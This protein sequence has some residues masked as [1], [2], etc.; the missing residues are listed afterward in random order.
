M[1]RYIR[2]SEYK[3]NY[4]QVKNDLNLLR[5]LNDIAN[6]YGAEIEIHYYGGDRFYIELVKYKDYTVSGGAIKVDGEW[7]ESSFGWI[8]LPVP[9]LG[10]D[11]DYDVI[12]NKVV[13]GFEEFDSELK[14]YTKAVDYLPTAQRTV[15]EFCSYFSNLPF[16]KKHPNLTISGEAYNIVPFPAQ[17]ELLKED[18]TVAIGAMFNLVDSDIYM[19]YR[20]DV[21]YKELQDFK[22][23][24]QEIK[25]DIQKEYNK[26]KRENSDK[27]E[28]LVNYSLNSIFKENGFTNW[29]A[30]RSGISAWDSEGNSLN[31]T[32]E[33]LDEV[34]QDIYEETKSKAKFKDKLERYLS[35]YW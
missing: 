17:R 15:D 8:S 27:L 4:R 28:N 7:Y 24:S 29:E 9:E 1:K 19:E 18:F 33:E 35:M 20:T 14:G 2:S 5:F 11:Y 10:Q 23:L 13:E 25:K 34:I 3:T 32:N 30:D 6:T 16:S 22:S 12:E 31:I 21:R 26:A